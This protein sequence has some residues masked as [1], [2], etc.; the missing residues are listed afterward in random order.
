MFVSNGESKKPT[1]KGRV[2]I[3]K[4]ILCS[5]GGRGGEGNWNMW[6]IAKGL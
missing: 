5:R 2:G 6:P 3:G 1:M 4:C